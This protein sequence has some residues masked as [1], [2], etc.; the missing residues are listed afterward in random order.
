MEQLLQFNLISRLSSGNIFIDSVIGSILIAA[1][2][3][4]INYLLFFYEKLKDILKLGFV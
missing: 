1:Y 3:Y 4:I 2:P